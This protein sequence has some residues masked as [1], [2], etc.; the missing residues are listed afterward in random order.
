MNI[1]TPSMQ[2]LLS[3]GVHFGHKISRAH[4][5]MKP[6][7]FG[8][9][10]GVDIIDLEKSH[11]K[12]QQA[13]QV[14]Y[15]MGKSGGVMLLVGTKKQA[16]DIIENLA[17]EV[18]APYLTAHWIGGLL[19]NFEEISKNFKKLL[20]LANQ[21]QAGELSRYT[22]KE[23][24]LISRRLTKFNAEAGGVANL[25]KIPQ[26][27]FITDAVS[28]NTAIREALKMGVKIFGLCDSNADPN[29]F[30]WPIP[31]NDDGIKSLKLICET[32][33]KAYGQGKSEASAKLAREEKKV[34]QSKGESL[35]SAVAE[36]A[37]VLEEV[38]EKKVVEESERKPGRV[39]D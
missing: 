6:F 14:A 28:E 25:E 16:K 8:S 12:L 21:Q 31:A 19:T 24:L 33:I 2:D 4:P 39:E 38:V 7:I 10:D 5:K 34:Q 37:A 32:V 26:A 11:E 18:N 1:S 27:I 15:E 3:A 23:Q 20:D 13:S 29:L 17:K 9:R 30:D 22:K 36:E 35:D